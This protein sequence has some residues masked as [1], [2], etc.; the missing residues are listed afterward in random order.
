[1]FAVL[2][3]YNPSRQIHARI[4]VSYSAASSIPYSAN[5]TYRFRLVV[6]VP[7]HTYSI[8]VRAGGG[9]EQLVGSN[10]GFRTEQ[11]TVTSLDWWG[12]YVNATPSASLTACDFTISTPPPSC[13]VAGTSTLWR[14]FVNAAEA[15]REPILPDFSYAGYRYS[16]HAIPE[17]AGPVFRVTDYGAVA[18]DSGFDDGAIQAAIDA[19]K[20]AG[21]GVVLFPAGQ[22]RVNPTEDSNHFITINGSNIVLRGAGSGTGGTEIL[23]VAKKQGGAMFR[24]SP[25]S[26]GAT[27]VANITANA[28]RE[29]FEVTVDST[30]QLSVGQRVLIRYQSTEY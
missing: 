2:A 30:A 26:W 15:G 1:G 16:D 29:A 24:V 20:A 21:G 12:A 4:S 8:F 10:Y 25:T 18:N 5:V 22:L 14:D 23:M 9:S 7:A 13:D 28:T 27:T 19:A 17:V 3:Q 6:N 11:N